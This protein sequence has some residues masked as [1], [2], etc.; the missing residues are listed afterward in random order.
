[1]S[2]YLAHISDDKTRTQTV[3]EHLEQTAQLAGEFARPFGAEE[4]AR[5]TAMAHDIGKFTQGFQARLRGGPKVDH[6]TAGAV[7]LL[8]A[9]NP[10]GVFCAAGH[11]TGLPDGGNRRDQEGATLWG[12]LN[13]GAPE[14]Y[15]P[16]KEEI[17][18]PTISLP[19]ICGNFEAAF[20]TRMLYSCLVDAD[21]LDTEAFMAG[22]PVPR[23]AG[24]DIPVLLQKLRDYT[25]PWL[26]KPEG[27]LN[28]RRSGI[29]RQCI[30]RG[31]EGRSGLYSLTVPTGGGKTISSLSFALEHAAA[32]GKRRVVY[33]IPYTSIIEQTA[34]TF[35]KILGAKNVLEHHSTANLDQSSDDDETKERLRLAAENWDAPIIVTTNVQFFES[36]FSNRS[37]RCRKNHRL[38]ESVLIFDEA[39]MLPLPYLLPCLRAIRCLVEGYGA[40]AVLCTATQPSLEKFF[41]DLPV[42][43]IC[44]NV[45]ELY[46]ALRRTTLRRGGE[47][48]LAEL[49]SLM[50]SRLAALSIVNSRAGAVELFRLLPEEGR[51][52]LTTLMTPAHRR[53]VLA[54]IR[55]RLSAGLPCRVAATSLVEAGV[56]LDFPAVYREEAGLDSILQAA[57]RCNREGKKPPEQS[58]VTTF[59]LPGR[60]AD[61]LA[62]GRGLFREVAGEVED[63]ASP[64]AI[65]LYFDKLHDFK[66]N[67][68]DQKGILEAIEKGIGGCE[69]PFAQ[70][71]KDFQL[72]QSETRQ[73]L[74]PLPGSAGGQERKKEEQALDALVS[75]LKVGNCSRQLLRQAGQYM[76]SVYPSHLQALLD[77][78]ACVLAPGDIAILEDTAR[79][80]QAV[81]LSLPSEGGEGLFF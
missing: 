30:Q 74:V 14:D 52:C 54:E 15:S 45:Q 10:Y 5:Q 17:Q 58:L 71:A 41:D 20:F 68:L 25:A 81:G 2:E 7:E 49:A 69:M 28:Q 3:R 36:L 44:P 37:S 22:H 39:Q 65:R 27:E 62:L 8:K 9:R 59:S 46:E 6:S 78:G 35:R 53:Q 1:M 66:G 47:L 50:E 51:F 76:V 48:T 24:E 77:T 29:L 40:T 56:D 42:E 55:R 32:H 79:Y 60:I 23:G 13:R 80:D 61:A 64:E 72:I 34:D 26:Q 73:I 11:H 43:E 57:G 21:F 18:L 31:R 67:A 19:P 70:V 16:W 63:P 38:A 75:A 33:V 12:R 4:A